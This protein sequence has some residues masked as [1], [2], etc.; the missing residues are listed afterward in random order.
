ML[1]NGL[2]LPVL[3]KLLGHRAIG[4]TLRY[5]QVTQADVHRAYLATVELTKAR[6]KLPEL[7]APVAPQSGGQSCLARKI[8]PVPDPVC[9]IN[10]AAAQTEAFRRDIKD[11]HTKKKIQRLVERLRRTAEDFK[12]LAL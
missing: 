10:I 6:Y 9:L 4:M 3:M 5:A 2:S 1:R 7:P 12:N 11:Q 8:V